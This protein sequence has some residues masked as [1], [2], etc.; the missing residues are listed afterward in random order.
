VSEEPVIIARRTLLKGLTLAASGLWLGLGEHV[1]AQP[2]TSEPHGAI[3]KKP[4]SGSQGAEAAS[5]GLNPNVFV[6][7][8]TDGQ[9]TIVCHRSEMGQGI[10][11]SLPVLIADELGADMARVRIVQAD[12]DKAYGDQNTDGSNS[13]RGLYEDMRRMG[14]T[15]RTMLV[16]VAA[17]RWRVP[18]A[19]C[20]ARDHSVVHTPSKRKVS[21][22][23]LVEEAAKLRVPPASEV[24][25]RPREE[26]P[27]LGKNL[28][29]LDGM[30][31]VTGTAAFGADVRLPGMLVA[32]I[33]RPP[34][35]GGFVVRFDAQRALAVPGVRRVIEL[36]RP[37]PPYKFQPWG[38]VAVVADHTWAALKGRDA[39]A[40]TWDHGENASY[41]SARYRDV[42]SKS[43]RAPGRVLRKVGNVEQA[44]ASA[45]RVIEAEYHVPHLPH[46]PM[47]PP[48]ALARVHEGGCE[49]WAPTQNPQAA[50]TE[51]ARVLGLQEK[52][53]LVHVT[54]L[55]GGFGRKSKADFCSEAAW[56]AREVKAPVRVQW[57]RE[58]DIQHDYVNTVCT[59][60][61]T[62]GL[63]KEG[64]V[65]AW[66]HR[67]AFP[68]IATLFGGPPR[69]SSGDLQQGVLDLAVSVP[70]LSAEAC[71][72]SAHTRIGW[73]R[74][75]YNIFQ[76]FSVGCFIDELAHAREQDPRDMWLDLFGPAR[77][78]SLAELGIKD[79]DNYGQPLEKHPVDVGRLRTV[80]ERVT[81]SARWRE[82]K[83]DGR[84]LGLAAHRSFLSYTAVVASMS[85]RPTGK[86]FVDEV[87]LSFDPG[88]I[89]N[90]DRVRAQMEGSI[91]FGMSLALFGGITM[92]GGAIEQT[93]FQGGARLV[94]I[95]EAP[96]RMHIDIVASEAAPGGVGEPGVPP[97]APA[98][99]NALF[100]LTGK[101]VRELPLARSVEV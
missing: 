72:A 4:A 53:V 49:V 36:P 32:V 75:V 57:T 50:Q 33:A 54:F 47:E 70:N 91:I 64:K 43:A 94:R 55:G 93:N 79:L 86:L 58:D 29:L 15:A 8:A 2:P 92:K 63:D 76:A 1:A 82:R 88:T 28:P 42:L 18:A 68:P 35:V 62:A 16:A 51:V 65:T 89:V 84:A 73:L 11:S 99:A 100:A 22:G 97:V 41:D 7:V 52:D 25:L 17:K 78:A 10:R 101:R 6:H 5:A 30:A 77:K 26:L 74:S 12:G 23:E 48:V 31:Y 21:F 66:R 14:A 45:S 3:A 24:V 80:I 40:I 56:L 37:K 34:V 87:W 9:V 39:L 98:I 81:E 83:K 27:H 85:K 71:E 95:G 19:E 61:L 44:L 69:P 96:R 90:A 13:I 20:T 60:Q 38:G 46:V 59:N 67:S